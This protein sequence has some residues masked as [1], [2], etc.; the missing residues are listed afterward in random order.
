[1]NKTIKNLIERRSCKDFKHEQI[2]D[3]DL[4]LI[5]K[6]GTFAPCGKGM[7]SPIILVL[8]NKAT[9]KKLSKLN[10]KIMNTKKDP[11]YNAPTI[12]IVMADKNIPTYREDASLV[13]GNLMNAAYSLEIG[14]CW[15]HRAK[16]EFETDE[17]KALLKKWKIPENYIGV[18]HCILG[19]PNSPYNSA[20]PRKPDY[21]RVV[22]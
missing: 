3:E 16:E 20:K 4:N 2:S 19:Y 12:L 1:M 21:I 11:F 14:P 10:A 13:L 22:K 5:L 18:G 8:Q 7:Q 17:G 15:I 6:A 9:I